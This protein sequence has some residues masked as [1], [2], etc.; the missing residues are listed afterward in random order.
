MRI[1]VIH[2]FATE[3]QAPTLVLVKL[4][5]DEIDYSQTLRLD[6]PLV[7]NSFDMEEYGDGTTL[8]ITLEDLI[9]PRLKGL[10]HSVAIDLPRILARYGPELSLDQ[11]VIRLQDIEEVIEAYTKQ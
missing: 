11:L 8:S 4:S 7:W 5:G 3:H 6:I 10:G 1:G 9:V 2:E